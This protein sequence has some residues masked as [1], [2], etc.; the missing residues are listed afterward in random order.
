MDFLRDF[1][2]VP[3]EILELYPLGGFVP[4]DEEY[5]RMRQRGRAM[6]DLKPDDVLVVQSGKLDSSKK[7]IEALD[8]FRSVP[9]PAMQFA[10]A[11]RILPDIEATVADRL[12]KDP[13]VRV[14]GWQSPEHLKTILCAADVYCQPGTQS[15]TMQMSIASRCAV[16]LDD[17][18]SHLPYMNENGWLVGRSTS[19]ED[20]FGQISANKPAVGRMAAHSLNVAS[21]MLDY[22]LLAKRLYQHT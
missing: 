16:I 14:L 10:V 9:D 15:A 17:I 13:R 7:L 20:A 18:P 11:G 4:D 5:F 21:Y 2:G 3:Q 19:I 22:R 6:L 8:A 1:Y 12:A